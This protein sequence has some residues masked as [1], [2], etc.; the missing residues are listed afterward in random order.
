[1]DD[2]PAPLRTADERA[3]LA[4]FLTFVRA[5][6]VAKLEDLDTAAATRAD[7]T[8]GLSLASIV[9]HLAHVERYWFQRV[10]AGDDIELPWSAE[11]PDAEFVVDPADRVEDVVAHY[12]GVIEVSDGILAGH[13]LDSICASAPREGPV[14]LRWIGWHMV[15]ETARHNGHLDVMRQALDGRTGEF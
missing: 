15:E 8:T 10:F 3:T 5:V 7:L 12:R 9:Q 4:S 1:M 6:A 11:A 2:R 14:T 13:E